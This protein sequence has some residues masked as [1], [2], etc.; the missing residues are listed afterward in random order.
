MTGVLLYSY[1]II[2]PF[3]QCAC[4]VHGIPIHSKQPLK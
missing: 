3:N 2:V 4:S 1:F